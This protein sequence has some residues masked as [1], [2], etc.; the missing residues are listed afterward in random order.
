M[1]VVVDY[2]F[3]G[4]LSGSRAPYPMCNYSLPTSGSIH[5]K[6]FLET[7]TEWLY[8]TLKGLHL[9]L[10]EVPYIYIRGDG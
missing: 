6:L 5:L 10:E 3:E 1:V 7:F 2:N 8:L 9:Q 4:S